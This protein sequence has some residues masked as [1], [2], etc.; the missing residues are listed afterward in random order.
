MTHAETFAPPLSTADAAIIRLCAIV[1]HAPYC[2]RYGIPNFIRPKLDPMHW[3][4]KSPAKTQSTSFACVLNAPELFKSFAL[5]HTFRLFK[6]V[7]AVIAVVNNLV[8]IVF[9][10]TF[11]FL[12]PTTDPQPAITG[13]L[14]KAIVYA[15]V[16]FIIQK[17]PSA[18]IICEREFLLL[19]EVVL[20]NYSSPDSGSV[21]VG[22]G[23]GFGC[24]SV[25]DSELDWL[26]ELW[27][28]ELDELDDGRLLE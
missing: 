10:G 5:K 19:S 4:S 1:E 11:G 22:S 18:F 6:G 2:P 27:L 23:S 3:L 24:G 7:T 21:G 16:R 25:F 14:S 8:K 20:L 15:P 13:W 28:D 17:L 26:D 12:F 9:K